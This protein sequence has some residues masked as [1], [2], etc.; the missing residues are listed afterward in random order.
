MAED[1]SP[2]KEQFDGISATT[3]QALEEVRKIIHN[4]RPYHLD[5]LGLKEALEFML[6]QV[7][8]V[9]DIRFSAEIDAVDGVFSKEAETNLYRIAQESINNIIKHSGATEAKVTLKR[10]GRR[11][12]LVIEDNGKGF[13]A[14]PGTSTES[15]R[16]GFGLTGVAERA[17]MLG[18][19]EEIHA[20]P[21]QGT[22]IT[23]TVILQDERHEK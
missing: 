18:G 22:T 19:K 4:L 15:R 11:V 2:V 1:G 9:S 12:Q 5:R 8:A 6:E 17:R 13:V 14:E 20:V 21:G 7:A 23:V 3:S 16:R 10:D